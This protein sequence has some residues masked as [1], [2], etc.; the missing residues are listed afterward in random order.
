MNYSVQLL[1]SFPL[2]IML[3]LFLCFFYLVYKKF[4]KKAVI[5]WQVFYFRVVVFFLLALAMAQ[6]ALIKR[7]QHNDGVVLLDISDSM[8]PSVADKL[9]AKVKKFSQTKFNILPFAAK[10]AP[11]TVSP[12]EVSSFQAL[13][14][15][16][17]KLNI[18]ETNLEEALTSPF[19]KGNVVLISD[20]N[21]TVGNSLNALQ[22]LTAVKIFPLTVDKKVNGNFRISQIYAPLIGHAKKSVELRT[23]LTNTTSQ[24]QK[25][26]LVIF[27]GDEQI[28]TEQ[29]TLAAGEEKVI[30]SE[31]KVLEEGIQEF[32]A[33]LEPEVLPP[34][35]EKIYV[36]A[37]ERE[38]IL[39]I[40]STASEVTFLKRILEGQSFKIDSKV[41]SG[42]RIT[43]KLNLKKYSVVIFNNV[44][45]NE[46]P[47]GSAIEIEKYVAKGGGFLMI[48]GNKSFGLGGYKDTA[49]SDILPVEV[50]TPKKEQKRVNV[51]VQLVL[52][53]SGSMSQ[54]RKIEFVRRGAAEVLKVLKPD[55][56]VGIIGFDEF[57]FHL[58]PIGKISELR[59]KALIRLAQLYP[60]RSTQ[61][62]SAMSLA[63]N[64]IQSVPAGRK[65]MIILTDGR[66]PDEENASYYLEM[67]HEMR[68][69]GITVST[70]II[71]N[72]DV[73]LLK[74]IAERGGG[75][76][77]RSNSPENLPR[78]FLQDVKVNTGERTQREDQNFPITIENLTSMTLKTSFPNLFGYIETKIKDKANLELSLGLEKKDPL[79]ASWRY[80]DGRVMAFTSD[81]SGRW[82]RNWINWHKIY[83]F[84]NEAIDSLRPNVGNSLE[85]IQYDLR[86][87]VLNGKLFLDLTIFSEGVTESIQAN[88]ILPNGDEQKVIFS[89]EAKGRYL[90]SL[91]KVQAG[92]YELQLVIGKQKFTPV[93]FS[94]S[95]ELFGERK[96]QPFNYA[97]LTQL[98]NKTGGKI[99]P[100]DLKDSLVSTQEKFPLDLYC[101]LLAL[102]AFML[103]IF[104]RNISNKFK[105]FLFKG[106]AV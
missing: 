69:R 45:L 6:P 104:F 13:K 73:P 5:N 24:P 96:G 15:T 3:F 59:S 72:D 79:L 17:N 101:C 25:G 103:E 102:V 40:S 66:L 91:D 95:G 46:L 43:E 1:G 65:H 20:G 41:T 52:D 32:F 28:F 61:L 7:V 54:G 29:V 56:Y 77:Y 34:S 99:N 76:F 9:L 19:L 80:K 11:F 50:M 14:D 58:V 97:R 83:D 57:P 67:A 68:L 63:K 8:E 47:Q 12:D 21:E 94:I 84:W 31:S 22:N 36:T 70:F 74:S 89:P 27:Q 90:S 81:V 39:I 2:V 18:G 38:K 37:N 71:G 62:M 33:V 78:L 92:K 23:S 82:S 51:A 98:A 60:A 86:N 30:V 100:D 44:P 48:G 42:K 49:I 88:V 64:D 53:K 93:A 4:I 16:W 85:N 26:R 87:Y 10:V 106:R 105:S 55:D 35:S 75:A